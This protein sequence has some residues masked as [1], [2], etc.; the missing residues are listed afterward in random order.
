MAGVRNASDDFIE[1]F[2]VELLGK[3]ERL[4]KLIT[5]SPSIGSYH[6]EVVKTVIR[7][8]MSNRWS[9][10][11]GF[12]YQD[13]D[14]VSAQ[15]DVMLVD[16]NSPSAYVFK[17]GNFAVVIPESVAATVE[18]KTVMNKERFV[19]S[20][21]NIE[22]AKYLAEYPNHIR[23]LVFSYD[24]PE[25]TSARLSE[26]FADSKL[27]SKRAP[28]APEAI[29]IC[30]KNLLLYQHNGNQFQRGGKYYKSLTMSASG[31]KTSPL[32]VF[33]ASLVVACEDRDKRAHGRLGAPGTLA[34]LLAAGQVHESTE[35]YELG[36]GLVF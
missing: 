36:K 10:R 9:T 29:Y 14:H 24:S 8:F 15:I 13:H 17:S 4:G 18:V 5:H 23:G 19:S 3:F 32:R 16:E 6:E 21:L 2:S 28:Y 30:K 26:W 22:S 11:N 25:P 7:N 20:I 33:L 34:A 31:D 35:K 27:D 12:I 1:S